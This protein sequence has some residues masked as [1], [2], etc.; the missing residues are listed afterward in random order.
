MKVLET[1]GVH[2]SPA[3]FVK[4]ALEVKHPSA[5]VSQLPAPML[6]AVHRAATEPVESLCQTRSEAL[7]MMLAKAKE[8]QP[9]EEELKQSLSA[10]RKEVLKGKRLVLF[11][12]LLEQSGSTDT[13]FVTDLCNG[14]D[15]TAP[16]RSPTHSPRDFALRS[17]RPTLSGVLRRKQG[18]PCSLT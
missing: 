12:W 8:F 11:Q 1:V 4:E 14:F 9:A 15:L 7:R 10:R 5:T 13:R 3:D 6:A 18:W 2:R 16:C 17:F